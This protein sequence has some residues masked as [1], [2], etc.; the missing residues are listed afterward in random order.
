[1]TQ[2]GRA[3]ARLIYADAVAARGPTWTNTANS[4]RAGYENVW[5]APALDAIEAVLRGSYNGEDDAEA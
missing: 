2:A 5:V 3:R 1:L 4:I